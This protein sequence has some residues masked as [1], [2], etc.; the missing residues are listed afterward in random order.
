MPLNI[1][2][3]KTLQFNRGQRGHDRSFCIIIICGRI[4]LDAIEARR[5]NVGTTRFGTRLTRLVPLHV[6]WIAITLWPDD[7]HTHTHTQTHTQYGAMP[8]TSLSECVCACVCV[9]AMAPFSL[10]LSITQQPPRRRQAHYLGPE[11]KRTRGPLKLGAQT[12]FNL[13]KNKHV[14]H[15]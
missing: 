4:K 8:E 9:A 14:V 5:L 15:I 1:F 10:S 6:S 13:K 2:N 12:I 7:T 3:H 11:F